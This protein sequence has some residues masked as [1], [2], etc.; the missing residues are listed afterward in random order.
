[1]VEKNN[2]HL[3]RAQFFAC[4]TRFFSCARSFTLPWNSRH[5][6]PLSSLHHSFVCHCRFVVVPIRYSCSTHPLLVGFG[7]CPGMVVAF[8]SLLTPRE[9]VTWLDERTV[10]NCDN[11]V[12]PY[13][14]SHTFMIFHVGI[15][16]RVHLVLRC[17][18][19]GYDLMLCRPQLA[20]HSWIEF[21]LP[22]HSFLPARH[23]LHTIL[24]WLSSVR[25]LFLSQN[26]FFIRFLFVICS[27]L[28]CDFCH[29]FS[30][31]VLF[32]APQNVCRICFRK[33]NASSP[34]IRSSV[35]RGNFDRFLSIYLINFALRLK[36]F[37]ML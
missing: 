16:I 23:S 27:P 5:C 14:Y 26:T 34:G 13:A 1:M 29:F 15:H 11:Q 2:L 12:W 37:F 31:R 28:V 32:F 8:S 33:A 9:W 22:F 36:D 19:F 30:L 18:P 24:V 21:C 7:F 35:E 6:F 20:T 17:A 3:F 4:R 25:V 10:G